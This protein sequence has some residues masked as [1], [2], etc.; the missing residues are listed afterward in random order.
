M[1]NNFISD[2]EP[3]KKG[4]EKNL[5]P[6]DDIVK[7]SPSTEDEAR[8]SDMTKMEYAMRELLNLCRDKG[9]DNTHRYKKAEQIFKEV[10]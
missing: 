4:G 1:T 6:K 3:N 8:M 9:V 5:K 2:I 7:D 10:F